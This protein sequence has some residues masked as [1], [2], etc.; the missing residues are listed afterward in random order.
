MIDGL[1]D[2][3]TYGVNQDQNHICFIDGMERNL[4][5]FISFN[6]GTPHKQIFT[7]R[8]LHFSSPWLKEILLNKKDWEKY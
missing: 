1:I 6:V 3:S 8:I 7:S 4:E 2:V 5:L